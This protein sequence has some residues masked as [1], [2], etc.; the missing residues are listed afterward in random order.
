MQVCEDKLAN[1]NLMGKHHDSPCLDGVDRM[2]KRPRFPCQLCKLLRVL[3]SCLTLPVPC[4]HKW[5]AV[6]CVGIIGTI[7]MLTSE[8]YGE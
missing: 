7:Q 1:F 3:V 5:I 8:D 4:H 2:R 6:V